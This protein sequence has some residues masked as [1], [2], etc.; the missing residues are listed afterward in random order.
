MNGL[1]LHGLWPWIAKGSMYQTGRDKKRI[2]SWPATTLGMRFTVQQ[3]RYDPDYS[4]G[5]GDM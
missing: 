3:L 1:V 4:F 5:A 2:L